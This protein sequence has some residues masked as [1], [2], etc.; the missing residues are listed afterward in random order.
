MAWSN[1]LPFE[2]LEGLADLAL[3]PRK[4]RHRDYG[5]FAP[6]QLLRF[7]R[8]KPRSHRSA[9]VDPSSSAGEG[10]GN[11]QTDESN[12]GLE[13]PH[14]ATNVAAVADAPK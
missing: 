8:H 4:Q 14:Q 6:N 12:S 3:R 10:T 5:V 13:Q 9:S 11:N 2:P 1:F 7:R